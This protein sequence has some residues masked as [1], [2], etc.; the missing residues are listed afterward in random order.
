MAN[1]RGS[2]FS[3][4]ELTAKA[5]PIYI[6]S[7]TIHAALNVGSAFVAYFQWIMQDIGNIT[8]LTE[9]MG[10]IVIARV[11]EQLPTYLVFLLDPLTAIGTFL[12]NVMFGVVAYYFAVAL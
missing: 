2:S 4:P 11:N 5:V 7:A 9:G 12:V 1:R 6:A 3:L 8:R 10:A